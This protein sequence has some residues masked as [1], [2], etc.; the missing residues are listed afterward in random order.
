MAREGALDCLAKRDLLA[1]ERTDPGKL[2]AQAEA[3]SEAGQDYDALRF[4]AAAGESEAVDRMARRA[5]EEGDLFLY[6]QALKETGREPEPDDLLKIAATADARG[7][8][9]FARRAEAMASQD[10]SSDDG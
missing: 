4:L 6:L 3:F 2:K 1:S 7:L 5:V 8:L 9:S 10:G